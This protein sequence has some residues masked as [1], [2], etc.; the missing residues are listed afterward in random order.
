MEKMEN[1]VYFCGPRDRPEKREFV[2][3][4]RARSLTGFAEWGYKKSEKPES[5][6]TMLEKGRYAQCME[7]RRLAAQCDAA[8]LR[9][10]RRCGAAVSVGTADRKVTDAPNRSENLSA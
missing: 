8:W 2:C 4:S 9:W 10:R 7:A 5:V 1:M 6:K 3:G